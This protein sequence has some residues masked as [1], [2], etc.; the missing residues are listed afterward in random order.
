MYWTR[1]IFSLCLIG[2]VALSVRSQEPRGGSLQPVKYAGLMDTVSRYRGKV[3]LVDFWGTF[4]VPCKQ[5]FPHTLDIHRRY[6]KDGLAL[7]TVCLDGSDKPAAFDQAAQFLK[8]VGADG[9]N[10]YLEEPIDL[11]QKK[12]GFRSVPC[13]YVFSRQ[14]QWTRFPAT[15]NDPLDYDAMERFIV[16]RLREQ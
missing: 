16:E 10:L 2:I 5:S 3:V 9:A 15:D 7:V 11:W 4:C 13:Y 8:K 6:A 12:L 14:G 1:S